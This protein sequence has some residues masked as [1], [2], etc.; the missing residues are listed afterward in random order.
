MERSVNV[1]GHRCFAIRSENVQVPFPSRTSTNSIYTSNSSQQFINAVRYRQIQSEICGVQF[2]RKPFSN[3]SYD[4]WVIEMEQKALDWRKQALDHSD[5][6]PGWFDFGSWYN[7]LMLHRPCLTNPSPSHKSIVSCFTATQSFV[8]GSWNAVE[9]ASLNFAWHGV[10]NCFE[11]GIVLLYSIKYYS[12]LFQP[13]GEIGIA[14]ALDVLGQ[15]SNILCIL[16]NRWHAAMRCGELFDGVRRETLRYFY[17][18]RQYSGE[19]TFPSSLNLLDDIVLHRP[20][21]TQYLKSSYAPGSIQPSLSW[22][23]TSDSAWWDLPVSGDDLTDMTIFDFCDVDA[24]F[25]N[26]DW[27]YT[28]ATS[29][30]TTPFQDCEAP[31]SPPLSDT[32]SPFQEIMPD[33]QKPDNEDFDSSAAAKYLNVALTRLPCLRCRKR[34]IKCDRLLP[35]CQR[36]LKVGE[37]CTF[38]DAVM[39]QET[40]RPYVYALKRKFDDLVS[41]LETEL[42]DSY[43][44]LDPVSSSTEFALAHHTNELEEAKPE[45]PSQHDSIVDSK[46]YFGKTSIF[47]RLSSTTVNLLSLGKVPEFRT[48]SKIFN[49]MPNSYWSP[50]YSSSFLTSLP[51]RDVTQRLVLQYQYSFELLYPVFTNEDIQE[52]IEKA[53]EE[54]PSGSESHSE[55]STMVYLILAVVARLSGRKD[56]RASQWSRQLFHRGLAGLYQQ[57][58]PATYEPGQALRLNVILCWYL[59]LDPSAGNIWRMLGHACRSGLE[60]RRRLNWEKGNNWR[61]WVT[62]TTL[63]RMEV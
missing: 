6:M 18:T 55:P 52:A 5:A 30:F 50:G 25:E 62:H 58:E 12:E 8:R 28:A 16:S 32:L 9:S 15:V 3:P 61:D 60:L 7:L 39:S 10:H 57:K 17:N 44:A 1:A 45:A 2:C 19:A 11:A 56:S 29:W 14:A 63:F 51:P 13:D 22:K 48:E 24:E 53:Y 34:R 47:S 43:G 20:G 33:L 49:A 37:E 36:C 21:D 42:P 54:H 31:I 23:D 59:W 35:T 4:L 46:P 41:R 26:L 27:A 38:Y 40:P